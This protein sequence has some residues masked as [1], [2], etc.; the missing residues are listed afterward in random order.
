PG[1]LSGSTATVAVVSGSR[2]Y[3][4]NVGDSRCVLSR[5]GQAIDMSVD[6][7]PDDP[8]EF[9][10]IVNAGGSVSEDGRVDNCLNLSRAF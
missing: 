6:H 7:K 5:N 4:A 10:R 1:Y 8:G 3:V 9:F 2:I